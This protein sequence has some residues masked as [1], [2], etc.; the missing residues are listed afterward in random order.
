LLSGERVVLLDLGLFVPDVIAS[1]D[2]EPAGSVHTIAPEVLL[3]DVR[4]G[5]A[6]LVDLYALGSVAFQ[7]LT[8]RPPYLH[9]SIT[10]M[11]MSHISAPVPDPREHRP[12]TSA[13]LAAL[14]R[15][16]LA[17]EPRDR[18]ACAEAVV[19]QLR[20]MLSRVPQSALRVL[21]VDDEPEVASTIRRALK[22]SYPLLDVQTTCD[23]TRALPCDGRAP[24]DVVVVDMQ[25]PGTNGLEVCASLRAL[26]TERRP[27]MIVMSGSAGPKDVD[28]LRGLGIDA[29]V[30]KDY[31]LLCAV[32]DA[33]G[34][35]RASR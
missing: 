27:T 20:A 29:F 15:E 23:A 26:P 25:M 30:P 10:K 35:A 22:S 1:T 6:P 16:L 28:V 8:G 11:M 24:A 14:V 9:E 7:L 34:R 2:A 33:I 5:E 19:W 21:V 12:E 31:A 17:K 32:G 18:P 3:R 13:D 4:S